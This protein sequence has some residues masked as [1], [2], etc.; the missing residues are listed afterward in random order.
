[1]KVTN[2]FIVFSILFFIFGIIDLFRGDYDS[3]NFLWAVLMISYLE[4]NSLDKEVKDL[5]EE[6]NTLKEN[7]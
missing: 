1:M 6:L 4:F 5:K 2:F 7:Q 3:N